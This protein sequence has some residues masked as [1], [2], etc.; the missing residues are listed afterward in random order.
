MS[1]WRYRNGSQQACGN[2]RRLFRHAR[3]I[4]KTYS[5]AV[6]HYSLLPIPYLRPWR[7]SSEYA[8]DDTATVYYNY[9]HYEPATGRWMARDKNGDSED[10]NLLL[11][12]DN[13]PS[14]RF[15][16]LGN[17]CIKGDPYIDKREPVN[18]EWTAD[19]RPRWTLVDA[20]SYA[21]GGVA[22][23]FPAGGVVIQRVSC[24]CTYRVTQPMKRIKARVHRSRKD[25][26]E[27]GVC[28]KVSITQEVDLGWSFESEFKVDDRGGFVVAPV[29]PWGGGVTPVDCFM[30]CLAR[31]LGL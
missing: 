21:V 2:A 6:I 27:Y 5:S 20:S 22:V 13:G 8:E 19:G 11:F 1:I 26:C 9:R 28:P 18:G 12:S 7:F 3:R 15:D 16:V 29:M 23:P 30:P 17:V 4:Q 31:A 10:K 24:R 25:W 14:Q